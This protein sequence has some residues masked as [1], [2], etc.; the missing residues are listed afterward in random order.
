MKKSIMLA[1]SGLVA[2]AA[3]EKNVNYTPDVAREM[4]ELEVSVPQYATK[5]ED[6]ESVVS[7]CQVLVYSLETGLLEAYSRTGDIV[8]P[9]KIQCTVGQ[10]EVVVLGNAPD[11]SSMVKLSDLKLARSSL[12]HNAV[13]AL[14]MEGSKIVQLTASSSESVN[15]RR[16]VSK[17]RFKNIVTRFEQEG[18]NSLEFKLK[19]VYLIN[20]PADKTY[21]ATSSLSLGVLPNSWYCKDEF[22]GNIDGCGPFLYHD[23]KGKVL[24]PGVEYDMGQVLYCCPNPYTA[25]SYS[26]PWQPR[27]TR[28]VVEASIGNKECCYPVTL[29]ELKQN[30]VYDVSLVVTRPGKTDPSSDMD[31]YDELF[32][33]EVLGWDTGG[34]QNEIL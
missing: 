29:P 32:K 13:G 17:I 19:S 14:V 5:A 3:C 16:V 31:K 8:S 23:L 27:P 21:L 1:V 30:A 34:T 6:G 18:Y 25:E 15:I 26:D 20:V 24:S 22:S 11:M 12:S 9:V 4:V 2:L 10:K 28:M 7:D 33:I